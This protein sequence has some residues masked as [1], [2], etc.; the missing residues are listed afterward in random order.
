MKKLGKECVYPVKISDIFV[1]EN[2][3]FEQPSCGFC[4]NFEMG[5]LHV[6]ALSP[7]YYFTETNVSIAS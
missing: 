4:V 2:G 1:C 5:L 7:D 3:I 6:V